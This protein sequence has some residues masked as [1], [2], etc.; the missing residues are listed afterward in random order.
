LKPSEQPN[1][2]FKEMDF[3][4]GMSMSSFRKTNPNFRLT[5]SQNFYTK[6]LIKNSS[7]R[8]LVANKQLPSIFTKAYSKGFTKSQSE[9]IFPERYEKPGVKYDYSILNQNKRKGMKSKK[10][11]EYNFKKNL[12]VN[13]F[14]D[15][16][17]VTGSRKG[18]PINRLHDGRIID[19]ELMN[20]SLT[21]FKI[22]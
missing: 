21:V 11:C 12:Y 22:K 5:N 6:S 18:L 20:K 2:K 10:I 1:I 4:M 3:D 16:L 14:V 19:H 15:K 17:R 8:N 13:D 9:V 7:S